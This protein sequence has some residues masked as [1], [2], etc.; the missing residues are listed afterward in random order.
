MGLGM[1]VGSTAGGWLA[2]KALTRA[3]LG[4]FVWTVATLALFAAVAS[5]VWLAG[6]ALFLVGIGFGLVPA[7]QAR[8]LDAAPRA[9]SLASAMNHSAFNLSNAIGAWTGGLAISGGLG[10]T[11]TGYV[12]AALALAGLLIFIIALKLKERD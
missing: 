2:D 10:W 4:F 3:I 8:L 1:V 6:L 11:A 12:G 7:L 9:Q 5:S